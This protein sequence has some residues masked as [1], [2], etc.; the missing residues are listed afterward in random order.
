M[1]Q[2][3][4]VSFHRWNDFESN[5]GS[6]FVDLRQ[7]QEF[8]DVTLSCDH[9]DEQVQAH[10]V[11]LAACSPFFRKILS[12]N[13]HQNPLIYLKGVDYE[14][15]MAVLN[16]MYQGE[17]NVA[18]EDLSAFLKV[19]EELAVKG[20]TDGGKSD[21]AKKKTGNV[22]SKKPGIKRPAPPMLKPAPSMSSNSAASSSSAS[23]SSKL[24]SQ[25]PASSSSSSSQSTPTNT[26]SSNNKHLQPPSSK[27][28]KV[29]SAGSPFTSEV[30]IHQ[31]KPAPGSPLMADDPVNNSSKDGEEPTSVS[32]SL[33]GEN[34]GDVEEYG[35]AQYGS[36]DGSDPFLDDSLAA[37]DLDGSIGG[38]LGAGGAGGLPAGLDQD[39]NK[40]KDMCTTRVLRV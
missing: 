24:S 16:F 9:G 13:P 17:V 12:R 30:D 38:S 3:R 28:Q 29:I 18:Q 25:V 40:G 8:F 7:N 10:K 20:L 14:N 34:S 36:N 32:A 21:K 31:V 39:G 37:D 23:A 2:V 4:F 19:A 22:P 1:P 6:S 26:F 35:Y 27:K 15:L 33:T 11:V 5:L